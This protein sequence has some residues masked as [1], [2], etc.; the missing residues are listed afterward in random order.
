MSDQLQRSP[1]EA[2]VAMAKAHY[3][4]GRSSQRKSKVE[5]SRHPFQ[6]TCG[7]S[8]QRLQKRGEQRQ[9]EVWIWLSFPEP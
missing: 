7:L 3:Q 2:A 1:P 5:L 6:E 9:I 8:T 4:N